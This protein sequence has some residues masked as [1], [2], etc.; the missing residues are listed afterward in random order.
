MFSRKNKGNLK[1]RLEQQRREFITDAR[2]DEIGRDLVRTAQISDEEIDQTL[3][4]PFIYTRLRARIAREQER[5]A[6]G[7]GS[8]WGVML[9]SAWRPLTGMALMATFAAVLFWLTA[10]SGTTNTNLA[11]SSNDYLA[12]SND[13]SFERIV[14]TGEGAPSNND[15]L[16]TLMNRDESEVQR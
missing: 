8:L 6:I 11:L 14:F 13:S 9:L 1:K 3:S 15:V 5:V 10:M 4:S 7:E 12:A 2:L 16:T